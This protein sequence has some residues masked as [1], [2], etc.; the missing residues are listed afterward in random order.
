MIDGLDAYREML[1]NLRYLNKFISLYPLYKEYVK[2]KE[3]AN[4]RFQSSAKPHFI[5]AVDSMDVLENDLI[6]LRD[7]CMSF[8]SYLKSESLVTILDLEEDL[9]LEFLNLRRRFLIV[10]EAFSSLTKEVPYLKK[11]EERLKVKFI[12]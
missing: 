4:F 8:A 7:N 3:T 11:A 1:D 5:K 2:E 6:K 10:F 12:R 9:E